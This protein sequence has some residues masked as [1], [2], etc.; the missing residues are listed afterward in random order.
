MTFDA[1]HPL[2]RIIRYAVVGI[3]MIVLCSTLYR[4]G[5]DRKDIVLIATTLLSL[6]GFD[7]IKTTLTKDH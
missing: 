2:W 7:G 3:V 5:F 1:S 6:V 4:H